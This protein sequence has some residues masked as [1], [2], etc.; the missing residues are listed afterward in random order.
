MELLTIASIAAKQFVETQKIGPSTEIFAILIEHL[1]YE[2]QIVDDQAL[3]CAQCHRINV[4]IDFRQFGECNRWC[5]VF[6]QI[7]QIAQNR[8]NEFRTGS[9]RIF[10]NY[11]CKLS[12]AGCSFDRVL[13]AYLDFTFC[14]V[15]YFKITEWRQ[16]NRTQRQNYGQQWHFDYILLRFLVSFLPRLWIRASSQIPWILIDL[17]LINLI[18]IFIIFFHSL[19]L[20]EKKIKFF[21]KLNLKFQSG[22]SLEISISIDKN[23]KTLMKRTNSCT[24]NNVLR[25]QWVLFKLL[26]SSILL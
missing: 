21:S 18:Q 6:A 14:C 3:G 20:K 1:P 7:G 26:L 13:C 16:C 25:A 22:N 2:I 5:I 12:F 24:K 8:P 17:L 11:I 19:N 10:V 15:Q 9:L 4:A 23:W